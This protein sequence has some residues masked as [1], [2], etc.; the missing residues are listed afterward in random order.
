MN[1][2]KAP[3]ID[4]F[5][6][7]E[8]PHPVTNPAYQQYRLVN[9]LWYHINDLN[10]QGFHKNYPE[11]NSCEDFDVDSD[12]IYKDGEVYAIFNKGVDCLSEPDTS[13]SGTVRFG[14]EITWL[15]PKGQEIMALLMNGFEKP[16]L[17]PLE[18]ANCELFEEYPANHPEK[19]ESGWHTDK[20]M[21]WDDRVQGRSDHHWSLPADRIDRDAKRL[22]ERLKKF[23]V[24]AIYEG[25]PKFKVTIQGST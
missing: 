21:G 23:G 24:T 22:V 18:A 7:S 14:D 1:D 13:I 15:S 5:P 6:I 9:H 4:G 12:I 16:L 25:A 10:E 11:L 3:T 19:Y 17:S 20:E 2:T 8:Y